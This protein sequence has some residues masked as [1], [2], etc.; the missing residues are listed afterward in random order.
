M[1]RNIPAF[2]NLGTK[3]PISYAQISQIYC[4]KLLWSVQWMDYLTLQ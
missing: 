3:G 1:S 2:L 4:L